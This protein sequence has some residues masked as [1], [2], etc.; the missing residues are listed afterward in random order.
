MLKDRG[1]WVIGD[2][3]KDGV[4]RFIRGMLS[5]RSTGHK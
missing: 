5:Q 2:M 3:L 4:Q 1:Q